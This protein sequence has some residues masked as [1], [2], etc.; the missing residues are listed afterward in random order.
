MG[1]VPFK[2]GI[3]FTISEIEGEYF[4]SMVEVVS[5][6]RFLTLAEVYFAETPDITVKSKC[7][8]VLY[9]NR[10][11][12]KSKSDE[13]S[14]GYTLV[15]DLSVPEETLWSKI[16]KNARYDI[17][18]S[19]RDGITF[20]IFDSQD[21][22]SES[23]TTKMD[24]F[25]KCHD[26]MYA[27][28]GLNFKFNRE[29]IIKFAEQNA[30]VITTASYQGEPI[31]WHFYIKDDK[32]V[33]F[34]ISCSLFRD[35]ASKEF[36]DIIGRANK[37]LH[38]HDLKHFKSENIISYDWGGC[39]WNLENISGIDNFKLSFGGEK[40]AYYTEQVLVSLKAKLYTKVMSLCKKK[41]T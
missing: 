26:G 17:N 3:I 37:A 39:D 4:L 9:H 6:G 24:L 23:F 18:C 28:K 36:I 8:V 30:A 27:S 19:E 20:E 1:G 5:K 7:D 21:I 34:T 10:K 31:V 16:R 29:E 33:K 13:H 35:S 15:T 2:Y 14:I 22:L 11:V 25:E 32:H 40:V 41:N 12:L 38:W